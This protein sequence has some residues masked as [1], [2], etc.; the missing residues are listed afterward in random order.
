LQSVRANCEFVIL[1]R[2]ISCLLESVRVQLAG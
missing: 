1:L 2:E